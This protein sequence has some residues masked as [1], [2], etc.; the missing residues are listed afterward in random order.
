[1]H[2]PGD[3]LILVLK[4]KSVA[5]YCS[6]IHVL[7]KSKLYCYTVAHAES[8]FYEQIIDLDAPNI[9]EVIETAPVG[10]GWERVPEQDPL[11]PDDEIYSYDRWDNVHRWLKITSRYTGDHLPYCVRRRLKYGEAHEER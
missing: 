10:K 7:S 1:M 11:L 6:V 2:K 9:Q 5:L 3:N 4:P 8:R